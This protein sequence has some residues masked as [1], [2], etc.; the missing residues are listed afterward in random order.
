[1][2]RWTSVLNPKQFSVNTPPTTTLYVSC[3]STSTEYHSSGEGEVDSRLKLLCTMKNS[4]MA[5]A[6]ISRLLN[7]QRIRS[8]SVRPH[9]RRA[10]PAEPRQNF[11]CGLY[12]GTGTNCEACELNFGAAQVVMRRVVC[13]GTKT[14]CCHPLS[15]SE[16]SCDRKPYY[17]L[18][19][20]LYRA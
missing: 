11:G 1:V 19:V 12:G 20:G 13:K 2:V 9:G 7:T 14:S 3:T 16:P 17:R 18:L 5:S 6:K 4:T 8:R 10:R 15:V